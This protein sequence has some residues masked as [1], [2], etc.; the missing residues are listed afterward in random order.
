MVVFVVIFVCILVGNKK[1]T[2]REPI[3][4]AAGLQNKHKKQTTTLTGLQTSSGLVMDVL[5]CL[6]GV[7]W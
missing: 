4:T 6:T 1:R 7:L 2:D 5:V 3:T